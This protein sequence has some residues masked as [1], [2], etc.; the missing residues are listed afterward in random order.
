MFLF[1]GDV[2][3]DFLQHLSGPVSCSSTVEVNTATIDCTGI[4]ELPAGSNV[5]CSI[6]GEPTEC[7]YARHCEH[8]IRMISLKPAWDLPVVLQTISI[9]AAFENNISMHHS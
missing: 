1:G 9:D 3:F 8:L 5:S 2:H 6:D 4:D 7:K